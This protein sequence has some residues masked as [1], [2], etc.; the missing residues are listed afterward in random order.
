MFS[1]LRKHTFHLILGSYR[2]MFGTHMFIRNA[3]PQN[4][5]LFIEFVPRQGLFMV[6]SLSCAVLQF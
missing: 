1:L 5:T 2:N 4:I 3:F 6:L